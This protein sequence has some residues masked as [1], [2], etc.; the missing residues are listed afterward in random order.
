[1]PLS[2][3]LAKVL[4][5]LGIFLITLGVGL[6]GLLKK[7]ADQ[8]NSQRG[9]ALAAGVFLG[10]GL[11]HMLNN[12]TEQFHLLNYHY[13]FAFLIAGSIFLLLLI[14][15]QGSYQIKR[16]HFQQF[17]LVITLVLSF[18][19]LLMGI[20]LGVVTS[21]PML[22]LIIMAILSHKIA[23]TFSLTTLIN[24]SEIS[25]TISIGLILFFSAMLPIG[26]LAASYAIHYLHTYPIFE[27]IFNAIAAGLLIY[28]GIV[29]TLNKSSQLKPFHSYSLILTGFSTMALV[30]VWL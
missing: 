10:T 11:I 5:G 7:T 24:K 21:F 19:S 16:H 17:G 4:L 18:H 30:A 27:P 22:F 14:T 28:L 6:W 3:H 23:A 20:S 29:Y 25:F 12:A 2:L 13:P 15:E 26:V 1:M 9:E 8:Q